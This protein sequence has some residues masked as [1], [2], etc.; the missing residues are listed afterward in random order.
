MNDIATIFKKMGA[1]FGQS[2]TFPEI[3]DFGN[4]EDEYAAARQQAAV[5]DLNGLNVIRVSG[6]DH[7]DLLH[8][9][10]M[11]EL[12]SMKPGDILV[13]AFPDA[14]G[15]I[16]DAVYMV[17]RTDAIELITGYDRGASLMAWLD[18][19]IFI[20]D[21]SLT[22]ITAEVRLV[23]LTGP[24]AH[25]LLPL[26]A[27]EMHFHEHSLAGVTVEAA[28]VS[29][30]L[31]RGVLLRIDQPQLHRVYAHFADLADAGRL[32]WAGARAFHALRIREGIPMHGHEFGEDANPYEAGLKSYISYTK[33]C[34]IGQEVIARLDTYDKVKYEYTGLWINTREPLTPPLPIL[35]DGRE[36]G[37]VTS[38]AFLP[39]AGKTAAI[40]RIRRKV[41]EAP[42]AIKVQA[43]PDT[44]EAEIRD[45]ASEEPQNG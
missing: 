27:P 38:A 31:P 37:V 18:K 20:E 24:A 22:D 19:Y 12:R 3:M 32:T 16:V 11:N 21:V 33:G 45:F 4:W 10:S 6:K 28:M 5:F 43:G 36:V 29:G 15:K 23:L 30:L 39:D 26:Q 42:G 35:Q 1:R 7:A 25:Q 17:R 13:N 34:Y 8:R 14:K 41:I 2:G 44:V 40:A 9:L